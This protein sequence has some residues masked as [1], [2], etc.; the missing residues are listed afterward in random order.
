MDKKI[1][2]L[3]ILTSRDST[4]ESGI[5]T[6][7]Q[8][9][10]YELLK[11]MLEKNI[12]TID[13]VLDKYLKH[14]KYDIQIDL[15]FIILLTNLFIDYGVNDNSI[16]QLLLFL[17]KNKRKDIETN[18]EYDK[19]INLLFE[20]GANF[21]ICKKYITRLPNNIFF[22]YNDEIT[23][24]HDFKKLCIDPIIDDEI[25]KFTHFD[26]YNDELSENDIWN[27]IGLG[28]SKYDDRITN[29][30]YTKVS[31]PSIIVILMSVINL[32]PSKLC[33]INN[34]DKTYSFMILIREYIQ[35]PF[36][37][38]YKNDIVNDDI[39]N[40][41]NIKN[42]VDIIKNNDVLQKF[43]NDI[44]PMLTYHYFRNNDTHKFIEIINEYYPKISEIIEKID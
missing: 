43:V 17:L 16:K 27:Y 7:I 8:F 4:L 1:Q 26:N 39:L 12:I 2:I 40:Q 15:K 10:E 44:S 31:D 3:D 13:N 22:Y 19:V 41:F 33:F 25:I 11:S 36:V 6:L 14:K 23:I 38:Y 29:F 34:L 18:D 35:T 21:N 37:S 42:I 30:Y 32:F 9:E 28:L 20:H 24:D 5:I